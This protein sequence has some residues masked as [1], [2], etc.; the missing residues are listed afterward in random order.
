MSSLSQDTIYVLSLLHHTSHQLV[1][2]LEPAP[3]ILQYSIRVAVCV[4]I[5]K[6]RFE[7]S[8]YSAVASKVT[9]YTNSITS[10][11]CY[12]VALLQHPKSTISSS[13]R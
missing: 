6:E 11:N 8:C 2:G 1:A 12:Y 5:A 3:S 7:L 9:M 10:P 4:F 13:L